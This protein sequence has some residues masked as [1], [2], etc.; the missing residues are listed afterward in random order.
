MADLYLGSA[1][2]VLRSNFADR[3]VNMVY[4]DPPY[5]NRQR[6]TGEAGTFEDDWTW[7]DAAAHGWA[8]LRDHN[9]AGADLLA[10]VAR[11]ENARAYLG[12]I[13]GILIEVRRVLVPTGTLWLQFDDTM[14]AELRILGDVV[15]GPEHQIGA[16][17]WHRSS[18]RATR[19]SFA[20]VHDTIACFGRTR[21]AR[22]RLDRIG[23]RDFVH[24]EPITGLRVDGFTD[25]RL[26]ATAAER[27]GYP[28]QKPI[29]LVSQ[30]IRCATL[31]GDV[32]LDPTCGSGT[33]LVAAEQLSRRAVG[34][35][36]SEDALSAARARLM[37][38][39]P[40][41]P[42]LFGLAA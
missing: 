34:I 41:Q 20:R 27:V 30:F 31:P 18:G 28:T 38:P 5:G 13:A 39:E 8:R 3:S 29:A 14:G 26:N 24:G 32:V 15:F 7:S 23:Y 17:I 21:V 35:D 11:S 37:C 10:I 19:S 2:A 6:W 12:T 25:V 36:I 42:D 4:A 16:V 33:T 1:A 22:W 40:T 9:S